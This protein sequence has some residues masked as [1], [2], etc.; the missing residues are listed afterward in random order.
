M[1]PARQ[2][3][4]RPELRGRRVQVTN[5]SVE[6]RHFRYT[7]RLPS[8]PFGDWDFR[9]S[10]S[11]VEALLL[12]IYGA[13]AE[14]DLDAQRA[15]AGAVPHGRLLLILDAGKGSSADR[16]DILFPAVETYLAGHW[17]DGA[18]PY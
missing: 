18:E 8:R 10:L 11:H 2:P 13:R 4:V 15:W 9:H 12:V 6:Q 7:A 17:H 5:T 1:R 16:P 3:D 14:E